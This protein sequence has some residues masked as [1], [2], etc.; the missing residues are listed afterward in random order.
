MKR[1]HS[2]GSQSPNLLKALVIRDHG[3]K[4]CGDKS[5]LQMGDLSEYKC[6][7]QVTKIFCIVVPKEQFSL[8][9][10]LIDPN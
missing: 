5:A 1:I 7:G 10:T 8:V 6:A 4:S 3:S 2:S 9:R